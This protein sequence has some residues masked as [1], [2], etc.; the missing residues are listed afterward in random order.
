[1]RWRDY[2]RIVNQTLHVYKR[3]IPTSIR[4]LG[5][6][7]TARWV[8]DWL[9]FSGAAAVAAGGRRAGTALLDRWEQ[10]AW[11]TKPAWGFALRARR[12]EWQAM[13]WDERQKAEG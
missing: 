8:A 11:T 12:A 6:R 9:R 3:I 10:H 1:M 2:G 5:P 13:G 7:D 4:V